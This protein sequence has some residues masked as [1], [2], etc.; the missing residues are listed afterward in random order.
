[1]ASMSV[2]HR[3]M[4]GPCTVDSRPAWTRF[5]RGLVKQ[6][7]AVGAICLCSR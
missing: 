2:L 1:L 7:I 4:H 6:R 5:E 3:L